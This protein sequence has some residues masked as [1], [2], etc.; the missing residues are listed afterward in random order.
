VPFKSVKSRSKNKYAEKQRHKINI[1]CQVQQIIIV[2]CLHFYTYWIG[3][4]HMLFLHLVC[5]RIL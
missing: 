4:N 2:M 5:V 1:N 3:V